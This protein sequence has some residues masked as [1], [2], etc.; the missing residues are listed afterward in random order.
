[1]P[2]PSSTV[3]SIDVSI[4]PPCFGKHGKQLVEEQQLL[5]TT[6]VGS[7]ELCDVESPDNADYTSTVIIS[8]SLYSMIR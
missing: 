8:L 6:W 1:M 5:L 4:S 7:P 3:D 2:I